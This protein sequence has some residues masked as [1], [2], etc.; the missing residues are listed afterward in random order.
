M[1]HL[2]E[3]ILRE[4]QKEVARLKTKIQP[5]GH[6]EPPPKRD[7]K[8]AISVPAKVSLIAEIKFASPSAGLNGTSGN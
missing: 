5:E 8:A 7:F 3:K 1:H 6:N 2:L 4:K